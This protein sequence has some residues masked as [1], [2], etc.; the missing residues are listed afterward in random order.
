MFSIGL[1]SGTS[2]DG[3]DAALI[4]TDG[5]NLIIECGQYSISYTHEMKIVLKS[6]EFAMKLA[7]GDF[8]KACAD[9]PVTLQRYLVQELHYNDAQSAVEAIKH[10]LE[11]KL[12][13]SSLPDNL[14]LLNVVQ[15]S[16]QLHFETIVQL[17]RNSKYSL[18]DIDCIGYHGQTLFHQ[19]VHKKT[20]QI[21][22]GPLLAKLTGVRVINDFRSNDIALGGQGAPFAPLYH[23]AL[24]RRD[25]LIP[26][27]VINCGGIANIT[28]IFGKEIDEVIGFDTGPGNCLIDAYV[29]K[30]TYGQEF[31]DQDGQYA[32]Q[33]TVHAE[34]LNKLLLESIRINNT[35]YFQIPPP[36]SLDIQDIRFIPEIETLPLNDACATLAAFTAESIVRGITLLHL[37]PHQIPR[38][39][40]ISG[41]GAYNPVIK[42]ELTTRLQTTF[43]LNIKVKSADDMHWSNQAIEAQLMAYFAVRS[44]KNLPLSM[45]KTTGVPFPASGGTLHAPPKDSKIC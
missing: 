4:D 35:S 39:F 37:Q 8:K 31:M 24:A 7:A 6:A 1:M 38:L 18:S 40:V 20:I 25:Q 21:G 41:G 30:Q 11:S 12:N 2:M 36:K 42:Q 28:L 10:Y 23:Q 19:P 16:T 13:L 32:Q 14:S 27:A 5:D 15:L 45:P 26:M 3:I 34:T 29:K 9:F 17:L 33:G 43:D 22:D 44:L